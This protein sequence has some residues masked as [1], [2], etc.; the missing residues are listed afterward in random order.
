MLK[1]D[2]FYESAIS[3]R[4]PNPDPDPATQNNADPD[5]QP[6]CQRGGNWPGELDTGENTDLVLLFL[7]EPVV[8]AHRLVGDHKGM[9]ELGAARIAATLHLT[10]TH[11]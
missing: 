8:A 7:R 4:S 10:Y 3:T 9:V 5:P 6:W 2:F 11:I 1:Y